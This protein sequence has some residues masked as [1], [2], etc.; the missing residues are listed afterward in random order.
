MLAEIETKLRGAPL[1]RPEILISRGCPSLVYRPT[2][3]TL[4]NLASAGRE[5]L[6]LGVRTK[7]HK[8]FDLSVFLGNMHSMV[9]SEFSSVQ[10]GQ[11][12]R[13]LLGLEFPLPNTDNGICFCRQAN[14][15]SG[16]HQGDLVSRWL[17]LMQLCAK[18]NGL[19]PVPWRV[20]IFLFVP[21]T[22]KLR[23]VLLD[24]AMLE[25]S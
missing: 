21:M 19:T 20:T 7:T 25:S 6:S 14:Y 16:Y 10:L 24:M 18:N 11:L 1:E 17:M 15:V 3:P 2:W 4:K 9:S 23:I 8:Q 5:K 13:L 12:F 22:W